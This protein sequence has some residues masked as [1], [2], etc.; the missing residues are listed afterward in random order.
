MAC[1]SRRWVPGCVWTWHCDNMPGLS[2]ASNIPSNI[3]LFCRLSR[4]VCGRVTLIP[5]ANAT[6]IRVLIAAIRNLGKCPCPRCLIPKS[7]TH[8]LTTESDLLQCK[9]LSRSDTAHCHEK[10]TSARK[11]IYKKHYAVDGMQVEELLKD[12][13]LVPTTVCHWH[14]CH[15]ML[16]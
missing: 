2:R 11:L 9:V 12:E 16:G 5:L 4:K 6:Y 14:L 3:Y 1:A 15:V 10:I 7:H 8:L 13:S